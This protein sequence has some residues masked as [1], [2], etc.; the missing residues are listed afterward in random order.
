MN[1]VEALKNF[2]AKLSGNRPAGSTAYEVVKN[3]G[4]DLP[5]IRITYNETDSKYHMYKRNAKGV[6]VATY[7]GAMNDSGQIVWTAVS[8]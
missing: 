7:T 6:F 5:N 4:E 8:A 2:F 3:A 1:I